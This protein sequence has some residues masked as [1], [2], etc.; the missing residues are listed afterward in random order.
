[1]YL[2]TQGEFVWKHEGERILRLV[3]AA[4]SEYMV[5]SDRHS[6]VPFG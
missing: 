5:P 3:A 6:S 1:M 2:T 4:L